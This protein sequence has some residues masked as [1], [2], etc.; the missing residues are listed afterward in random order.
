MATELLYLPSDIPVIQ[1]EDF[2]FATSENPDTALQP[3]DLPQCERP[4]CG[5]R[6]DR[7]PGLLGGFEAMSRAEIT[8]TEKQRLAEWRPDFL[9]RKTK[10]LGYV[11]RVSIKA[12]IAVPHPRLA[13]A[14]ARGTAPEVWE[15]LRPYAEEDGFHG[16]DLPGGRIIFGGAQAAGHYEEKLMVSIPSLQLPELE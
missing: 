14:M 1:V 12:T 10:A 3:T 7:V 16:I 8:A 13:T 2:G 9:R 11:F 5:L 15:K 4:I 6:G